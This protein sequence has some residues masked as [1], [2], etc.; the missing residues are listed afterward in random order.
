MPS[1]M[2]MDGQMVAGRDELR[3]G[4]GPDPDISQPSLSKV[5]QTTPEPAKAHP[6]KVT[7]HLL[8][9]TVEGSLHRQ[10]AGRRWLPAQLQH[11]WSTLMDR[12]GDI[13]RTGKVMQGGLSTLSRPAAGVAVQQHTVGPLQWQTNEKKLN[14]SCSTQ[15]YSPVTCGLHNNNPEATFCQE[16]A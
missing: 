7:N 13:T 16:E 11:C 5:L 2:A 4:G 1:E 9:R 12:D 15:S 14:R 8:H 6:L 10:A 3:D